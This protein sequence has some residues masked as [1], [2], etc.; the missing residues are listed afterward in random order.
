M[1]I[2]Q[3]IQVIHLNQI[4]NDCTSI[5]FNAFQKGKVWHVLFPARLPPA[6]HISSGGPCLNPRPRVDALTAGSG[7]GDGEHDAPEAAAAVEEAEAAAGKVAVAAAGA[8]ETVAA[9]VAAADDG[10]VG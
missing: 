2:D 5:Y 7:G 1:A 4:K 3:A 9:A 10:C 6:T 8:G